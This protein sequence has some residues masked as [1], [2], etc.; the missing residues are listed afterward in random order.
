M[1]NIWLG[2]QLGSAEV[3]WLRCSDLTRYR[4][5]DRTGLCR[6]CFYPS[7]DPTRLNGRRLLPLSACSSE[8]SSAWARPEQKRRVWICLSERERGNKSVC[9]EG[10]FRHLFE[11]VEVCWKFSRFDPRRCNVCVFSP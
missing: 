11:F 7:G 1:V 6:V 3:V 5:V 8:G 4:T 9:R 10:P 2:V